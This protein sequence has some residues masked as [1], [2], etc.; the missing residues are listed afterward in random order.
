MNAI[1]LES[2]DKVTF[3]LWVYPRLCF[4]TNSNTG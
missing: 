3:L 4:S 2:Q 1:S